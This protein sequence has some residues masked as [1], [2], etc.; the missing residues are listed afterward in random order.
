MIEEPTFRNDPEWQY[1]YHERLG[2]MCEDRKPTARQIEIA[3][4]EANDF[5]KP[6][7]ELRMAA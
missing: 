7:K 2:I 5:M 3:T 1:R 4:Q 6:Q